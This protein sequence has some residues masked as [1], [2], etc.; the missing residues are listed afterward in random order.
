[1]LD[2]DH[3]CIYF[4]GGSGAGPYLFRVSLPPGGPLAHISAYGTDDLFLHPPA[5]SLH[6]GAAYKRACEYIPV[7]RASRETVLSY[8][9]IS[10]GHTPPTVHTPRG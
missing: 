9:H 5:M 4:A 6:G 10:A 7:Q 8:G 1:M 3:L 2:Y